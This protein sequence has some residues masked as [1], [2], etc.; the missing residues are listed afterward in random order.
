MLN[1]RELLTNDY[2]SDD[3]QIVVASMLQENSYPPF[4]G[5]ESFSRKHYSLTRLDR[6]TQ[7]S[8]VLSEF[9]FETDDTGAAVFIAQNLITLSDN[10]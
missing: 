2:H 4:G 9:R 7:R 5:I 10:D 6:N 1:S 3:A 8:I